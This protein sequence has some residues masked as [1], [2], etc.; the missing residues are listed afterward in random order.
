MDD[1]PAKLAAFLE[2]I[3]TR[4]RSMTVDRAAK[5]VRL[6]TLGVIAAAFGLM[7]VIFLFLT[8]YGALE[9]PLGGWGAFG[10]LAGLFA[11]AGA[12]MWGKRTKD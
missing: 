1:F 2:D 12:F 11:L 3:A 4:A 9:I 10:V 5:A 7:T 6:T 8:I